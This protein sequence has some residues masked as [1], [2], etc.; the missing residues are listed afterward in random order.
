M[1]DGRSGAETAEVPQRK[2][3]P[4]ERQRDAVELGMAAGLRVLAK[5]LSTAALTLYAM[6]AQVSEKEYLTVVG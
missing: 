3:P 1:M 4:N 5:S 6:A 2:A